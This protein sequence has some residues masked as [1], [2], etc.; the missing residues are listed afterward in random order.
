[1][2]N[3]NTNQDYIQGPFESSKY[4]HNRESYQQ[5]LDTIKS[6]NYDFDDLIHYFPCFTGHLTLARYL[7]FYDFYRKT[8]GVAGHIAEIGVYKGAVSLLFAK[9]VKIFE[10]NSITQV[11]GFDWFKGNHPG[12][13]DLNMPEGGYAESFERVS[14]LTA[15]QGLDNILKIHN[16][17]VTHQLNPFLDQWKHLQFKIVFLDCGAHEVVSTALPALWDRLT[18]GGILILDQYNFDVAPGEAMAVREFLPHA[19]VKTLQHG[20]MPTAYIEKE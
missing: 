1:M 4:S 19:K 5:S 2:S 13:N 17:D 16:L 7:S 18:P 6:L 9:L 12:P 11:H 10:P 8:L 20:W 3:E 14:A 15:S